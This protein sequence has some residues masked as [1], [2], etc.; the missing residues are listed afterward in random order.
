MRRIVRLPTSS[1]FSARSAYER[2]E[3]FASCSTTR[4]YSSIDPDN[5]AMLVRDLRS[6]K[7]SFAWLPARAWERASP[8]ASSALQAPFL[9]D[10]YTLE[11]RIATT[12]R[13]GHARSPSRVGMVG[14]GARPERASAPARPLPARVGRLPS[15]ARGSGS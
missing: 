15:A 12:D 10:G 14:A 13:A 3:A 11:A 1:T 4:D 9:I 5:E 6:G 8:T 2:A 7:A